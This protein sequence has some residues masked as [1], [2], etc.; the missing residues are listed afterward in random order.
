[1]VIIRKCLSA[2]G[3]CRLK[4]R[5]SFVS[6]SSSSSFIVRFPKKPTSV[7]Q[8]MTMMFPGKKIDDIIHYYDHTMSVK[9]ICKRVFRDIL[10]NKKATKFDIIE[11]FSNYVSREGY[12]YPNM[13]R[14]HIDPLLTEYTELSRQAYELNDNIK[15]IELLPS[16]LKENAMTE[17]RNNLNK[18]HKQLKELEYSIAEKKTETILSKPGYICILCYADEDGEALLEHGDIFDNIETVVVSQH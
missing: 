13:Y 10:K 6:N 2:K 17:N 4:V 16:P 12:Y 3:V 11:L 9:N 15:S 14:G 7:K 8:L 5:T 18:L 1:M